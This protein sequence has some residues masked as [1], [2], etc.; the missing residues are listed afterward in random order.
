M[1]VNRFGVC[2]LLLLLVTAQNACGQK[3]AV[4]DKN[5]QLKRR[6]AEAHERVAEA[7]ARVA[8]MEAKLAE[9][10]RQVDRL[11]KQAAEP[12]P[13]AM[14]DRLPPPVEVNKPA[15]KPVRNDLP[16]RLALELTDRS[17][18]VGI[19]NIKAIPV[20]TSYAA[21]NIPIHRVQTIMIT[22][23]AEEASL[24]LNNGDRLKG[25]VTLD[26]FT[27]TGLVGKVSI[28]AR[29]VTLLTVIPVG[30]DLGPDRV[31]SFGAA[32]VL[33]RLKNTVIPELDFRG[34]NIHDV[35]AFF[36]DVSRKEGRGKVVNIVL[37]LR[38]EQDAF[39]PPRVPLI[40]FNARQ[41]TLME[42][43]RIT[44]EVANLRYTIRG[45][46]VLIEPK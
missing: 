36:Q 10:A 38:E 26:E 28:P 23:A 18:L 15:K 45:G 19:P 12:D 41:I 21:M 4:A 43:L 8:A 27:I 7:N 24:E 22:N 6:I 35:I 32:E 2:G 3:E 16:L 37:N 44:T 39:A 1:R 40:T 34:A 31:A 42:A 25:R 30:E 14:P 5:A 13:F 46:I 9:M 33:E 20:K 17:C 11:K 29:H